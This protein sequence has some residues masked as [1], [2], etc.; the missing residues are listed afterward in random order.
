V[1]ESA[2]M[3]IAASAVQAAVPTAQ[4][5]VEV[6]ER[7]CLVTAGDRERFQA[8]AR[9][10]NWVVLEYRPRPELRRDWIFG[11]R[12]GQLEVR[13][14]HFPSWSEPADADGVSRSSREQTICS[15]EG[16]VTSSWWQTQLSEVVVQGTKLGAS[17]KIDT[18]LYQGGPLGAAV[19][20]WRLADESQIHATYEPASGNLELSINYFPER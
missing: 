15:V 19:S 3:L 8:T 6:F 14:S 17:E 16:P 7:A 20:S 10:E 18:S 9:S 2:V 4:T 11:F 12:A 13:L 1:L 5:P